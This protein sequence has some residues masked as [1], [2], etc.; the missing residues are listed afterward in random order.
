MSTQVH[1][2]EDHRVHWK[3]YDRGFWEDIADTVQNTTERRWT[4]HFTRLRRVRSYKEGWHGR[5]I[6]AD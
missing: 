4:R 5:P 1:V 2:S 3:W 6:A